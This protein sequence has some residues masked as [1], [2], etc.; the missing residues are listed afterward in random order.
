M[1]PAR[2]G[3]RSGVALFVVLVFA[4]LITG[5]AGVAMR[6]SS[7]GVRAAAVYLDHMRADALGRSAADIVAY[8]VRSGGSELRRGGSFAIHL[9]EADL[10]V[11]Y[12]SEA[13]R[14]DANAAPVSLIAALLTAA[15]ADPA[16]VRAV[17]DRISATR[18]LAEPKPG[19]DQLP[20]P[21]SVSPDRNDFSPAT[22]SAGG[23]DTD[24]AEA[25]DI[26]SVGEISEHWGLPH[27]LADRVL[28][29][30]TVANG[31][32]QVDP[33]LAGRLVLSALIGGDDLR[34]EDYLARRSRGFADVQSALSLLP[35]A[36]QAFV[37]FAPVPAIRALVSVRISRRLERRYEIVLM[38]PDA[39]GRKTK[40]LSWRRY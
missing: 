25:D 31:S 22:P 29:S 40:I 14:I 32:A 26:Q 17:A 38:L 12:L 13:A 28:P 37:G 35:L 36:S 9:G 30:L 8:Y 24:A 34:V 21:Q 19:G 33:T 5:L 11:T 2:D 1:I 6:S 27:E 23:A 10:S 18:R 7:S 3:R 15:D 4:A 20:A 39:A 16:L